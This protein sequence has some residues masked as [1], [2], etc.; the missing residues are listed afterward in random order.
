LQHE[1]Q[2]RERDQRDDDVGGD[3]EVKARST[4]LR[5]WCR[6]PSCRAVTGCSVV[7]PNVKAQ[8]GRGERLLPDPGQQAQQQKRL[9]QSV[10]SMA[11]ASM[12]GAPVVTLR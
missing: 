7:A 5:R 12:S 11:W 1:T 9:Q 2:G 8:I 4:R 10:S 6:A 3:K